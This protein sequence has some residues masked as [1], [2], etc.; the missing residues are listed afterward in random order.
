LQRVADS[1]VV[2]YGERRRAIAAELALLFNAARDFERA[3][4]HYEVA[5]E[6]AIQMYA[7][8]EAMMLAR[9]GLEAAAHLRAPSNRAQRQLRLLTGLGK[10]L[11]AT[12]SWGAAE[13]EEI[14]RQ[15]LEVYREVGQ[16]PQ[17]FPIV[18]GHWQYC[19]GRA[20]YGS[21][22]DCARRLS[23]LASE[24]GEEQLVL[25]AH[26]AVAQTNW[27][28][29]DFASVV[30]PAESAIALYVPDRHHI[31]A[32]AYGGH[33]PGVASRSCLALNL[34][35]LGKPEQA[36]RTSE[37][38]IALAQRLEHRYSL[39]F[40][41]LFDAMLQT[42]CREPERVLHQ[43]EAAIALAKDERWW[44]VVLQS[45][46]AALRGWALAQQGRPDHGIAL[47][48]DAIDE[49]RRARF[50]S[51]QPYFLALL[52]ES[53]VAAG[54]AAAGLRTLDEAL[55]ITERTR[56][57]YVEAELHRL[58]GEWLEDSA[59]KEAR[60]L[61][62]GD[63]ARRQGATA[64]ELRAAMSMSR[65]DAAHGRRGPARQRLTEIYRSFTEG[66]DTRDVRDARSLL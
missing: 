53:Y 1:L 4:E 37:D 20:N 61:R 44:A 36:V 17:L 5:V 55:A 6:E 9:Q 66:F 15:A 54:D 64:Y 39:V 26:Q 16:T 25:L 51:L 28:S 29:G 3:T 18:W 46:A 19:L 24:L 56:E 62:A 12:E 13:A 49:C 42:Q 7:M 58:Q 11:M 40:A 41:L 35:I 57:G 27:L 23:A 31:L 38:A 52:A 33:D 65:L 59:M 2:H 8:K 60:F 30:G 63:I 50:E 45:W 43:T 22:R 10:S 34:W 14:H 21:A 47:L 32:A 48:R